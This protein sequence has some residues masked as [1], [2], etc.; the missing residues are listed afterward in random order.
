MTYEVTRFCII[1]STIRSV[2]VIC[3]Y[4]L[5]KLIQLIPKGNLL[6]LYNETMAALS[7]QYFNLNKLTPSDIRAF[8]KIIYKNHKEHGRDYLPWRK[9]KNPYKILI[10]EVMLQQT[11]AGRVIQKYHDFLKAFPTIQALAQARSIRQSLRV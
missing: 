10:S 1:Y 7:T 9:T 2:V 11:Q 3:K 6:S 4:L 5:I 8:R